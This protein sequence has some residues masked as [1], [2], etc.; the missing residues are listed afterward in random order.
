[1]LL[2]AGE[3]RLLFDDRVLDEDREVLCRPRFA[4]PAAR[5]EDGLRQLEVE[6]ERV[7]AAPAKLSL[8]D[9]TTEHSSR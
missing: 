8:P 6:G 4:L 2:L 7:A 1:M 5:G 3:L 9:P